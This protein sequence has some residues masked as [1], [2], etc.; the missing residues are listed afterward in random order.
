MISCDA[1]ETLDLCLFAASASGDIVN[2]RLGAA[3]SGKAASGRH[4]RSFDLAASAPRA[5]RAR[6]DA[7]WLFHADGGE[8]WQSCCAGSA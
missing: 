6:R 4:R 8:R 7:I 3:R 2:S 5:R 1:N